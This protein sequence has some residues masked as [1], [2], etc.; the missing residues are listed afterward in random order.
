M[1]E[2]PYHRLVRFFFD[3]ALGS[4]LIARHAWNGVRQLRCTVRQV[5][6]TAK[7]TVSKQTK[8]S[9]EPPDT[10]PDDTAEELASVSA[11]PGRR[12]ATRARAWTVDAAVGAALLGWIAWCF[13]HKPIASGLRTEGPRL[14]ANSPWIAALWV[15]AAWLT[16]Q[17]EKRRRAATT[18]AI[19][20][21]K[22]PEAADDG[23]PDGDAVLAAEWWLWE[24]VIRRVDQ[25]VAA[26]R[27]GIHLKALLD[28][29]GLPEEWTVTTLRQHCERLEIP[30]RTMQ[31][32]GE[33]GPTHG[34]H[35]HDLEHTLGM[36]LADALT[37]YETPIAHAP[38]ESPLGA[39]AE[40][41]GETPSRGSARA[42]ADRLFRALRSRLSSPART[43][44]STPLP[45]RSPT[46]AEGG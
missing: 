31:I 25:A 33:G 19:T 38:Q 46:S 4:R 14:L 35:V 18:A 23:K 28:E 27:R 22:G 39:A 43:P 40:D 15:V 9:D 37:P 34:V 3:V 16:A 6:A 45:R 32:R 8:A 17:P 26:G 10:E 21:E 7:N 42:T 29:P 36:P 44:R 24:L 5:P 11:A 12:K 13:L 41:E 30:V 1:M 2:Q 20:Y